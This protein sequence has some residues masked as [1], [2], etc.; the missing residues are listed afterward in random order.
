MR[1]LSLSHST[2]DPG[3]ALSSRLE[4]R[5]LVRRQRDDDDR[6]VIAVSLAEAG[7][8]LIAEIF[9]QHVRAIVAEMSVLT[10]EEQATL[11]RLCRK[12]GKKA[13]DRS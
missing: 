9:P 4:A 6:R 13:E 2:C 8:A 1:S 11:G 12:L 5:D 10:A 7:E 3:A